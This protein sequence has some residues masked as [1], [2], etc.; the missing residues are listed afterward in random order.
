[1]TVEMGLEGEQVSFLF[2]YVFKDSGKHLFL[3]FVLLLL[4]K[5]QA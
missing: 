2:H 1:M 4:I 3:F 5:Q